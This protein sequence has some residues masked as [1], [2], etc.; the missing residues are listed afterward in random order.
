MVPL[1]C[2][3]FTIPTIVLLNYELRV[4]KYYVKYQKHWR[5]KINQKKIITELENF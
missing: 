5:N 3:M 4:N 1:G 2:L